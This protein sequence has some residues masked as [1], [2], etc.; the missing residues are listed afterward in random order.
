MRGAR[1]IRSTHVLRTGIIPAYAGSTF[2]SW[3]C[4]Q[5]NRD[6]PRVCGEHCSLVS[7]VSIG[8]GSSPRMRGA[9]G[10][11]GKGARLLGIIPAYA[12]STNLKHL[13]GLDFGDH[14]RVCGEHKYKG[15]FL[16]K[17]KGSSPRMRGAPTITEAGFYR[18][19]IIPAYAG[20]TRSPRLLLSP[21]GDHPRVCGEHPSSQ[22]EIVRHEGSSPR[23]RGALSAPASGAGESRIIPAYAGS[24]PA[25]GPLGS[26][27]WDHPRVCGEHS[28]DG[29]R[30]FPRDGSSPR[31]RGAPRI[32][33]RPNRKSGIIP[34][35]AGST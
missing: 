13:V 6:H 25:P 33:F 26:P 9:R 5:S 35:Y 32:T 22:R 19:G 21:S 31:M 20:S 2:V 12:G 14:P 4:P 28:A 34:A 1:R 27:A 24:T 15:E 10:E 30:D 8:R 18:A 7:A 17:V 11:G 3:L 23:M 29:G 16:Y